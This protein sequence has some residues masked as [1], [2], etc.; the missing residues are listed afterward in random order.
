MKWSEVF[1][2][3][4]EPGEVIC[5]QIPAI[6]QARLE[7]FRQ[8]CST[9]LLFSFYFADVDERYT[10]LLGLDGSHGESGEMIDFPQATARGKASDWQRAMELTSRLVE[11][12]DEQIERYQGRVE[13]TS[14][15][16]DG[17]ERFDGVL[18]IEITEL[19]DGP[20]L[21]FEVI[22]ND[23]TDPPRAPRASLT[24]TWSLLDDLAHA[25]IDPVAAAKKITLRGAMGLAIDL[26]GFFADEFDL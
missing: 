7:Q 21:I 23:Y 17:F 1:D 2:P 10:L 11:P 26:G 5:T 6:H 8:F 9:S 22:L 18:E 20:P 24:V 4:L 15:I 16:K 3:E 12:A 19:P 14:A 25:R 13:L